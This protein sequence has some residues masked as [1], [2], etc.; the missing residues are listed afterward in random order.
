[1][2]QQVMAVRNSV[3]QPRRTILLGGAIAFGVI[4]IC[5]VSG[6]ISG[7]EKAVQDNV[8]LFSAGHVLVNGITI[9]ESGRA[10]NRISAPALLDKVKALVPEAVSVSQ[11]AQ[12]QATVVFGSREQ[13]MRIRGVD[14]ESDRLFSGSL[15]LTA[16]SWDK[17][18]KDR[19]MVLGAQ[20][21][22]R[23]G[24]GLGDTVMVRLSTTSGQQNVTEY[25]VAAFYDDASS[26]GMNT[27]L[28]PVS[29]L[30]ADLNMKKGEY[31][32]LA[33][34]LR[35]AL[36][37]DKTAQAVEKGLTAAGYRFIAGGQG[38]VGGSAPS[39]AIIGGAMNG[40]AM[41][42]GGMTSGGPGGAMG[43]SAMNGGAAMPSGGALFGGA[44]FFKNMPAGTTLYRTATV[45]QMSGQTGAVLSTIK[46][47]GITVFLVM[48]VL[49]AAGITNT[50]RMVLLERTKEIGM[51]RCIGFK[52][53][54]VFAVFMYEALMIAL[55]GSMA[56]ILL[57]LPLGVLVQLIPF[58]PNGSLGSVL[59]RGHL[60]F[61]PTLGSLALV[62]AAVLAASCLA[63][64]S[65]ARRASRLKPVEALRTVA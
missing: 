1:M 16:G 62:V 21:A 55:A 29:D 54:D 61:A 15:V 6:F 25:A 27:A 3:R 37:A 13:Q 18:R 12:A 59:T 7:M 39:G 34:F 42:G 60:V 40:E 52:R 14:W 24:L 38:G 41:N 47:I 56:G 45:T 65:P 31:Q 51:L 23:F 36:L 63:V 20:S 64:L 35:D 30:L 4:I 49:V 9:S 50:Y 32:A 5:L 17:V 2:I 11:T 26:G 43:G 8:T 10:Q 22:K 33:I 58:D 19:T 57:S 28:V 46:W 53:K 44:Q 48:L